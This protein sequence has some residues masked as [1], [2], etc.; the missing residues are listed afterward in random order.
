MFKRPV[1][2]HARAAW[3]RNV[4]LL[5]SGEITKQNEMLGEEQYATPWS[6]K[7]LRLMPIDTTISI[8]R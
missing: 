8:A 1:L 3:T 2:I 7:W 4:K 6:Y 5:R